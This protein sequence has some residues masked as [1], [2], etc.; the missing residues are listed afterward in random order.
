[1]NAC[2][3]TFPQM[4]TGWTKY[5]DVIGMGTMLVSSWGRLSVISTCGLTQKLTSLFTI[6]TTTLLPSP[7]ESELPRAQVPE[8]R[9]R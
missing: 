3:D 5:Y 1:M 6:P 4:Q 8:D 2:F 9:D 7:A